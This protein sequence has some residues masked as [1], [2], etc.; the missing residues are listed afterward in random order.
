MTY[1]YIDPKLLYSNYKSRKNDV[2]SF[3]VTVF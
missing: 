1:K 3:G 2:Y